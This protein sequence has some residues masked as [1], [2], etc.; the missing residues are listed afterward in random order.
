MKQLFLLCACLM[1]GWCFSQDCAPKDLEK[2]F[3]TYHTKFFLRSGID[4]SAY[5]WN[6]AEVNCHLN[7]AELNRRQQVGLRAGGFVTLGIGVGTL[8][9]GLSILDMKNIPRNTLG[10][11]LA[12]AGM[13]TACVSIPLIVLQGVRG[14]KARNHMNKAIAL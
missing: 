3:G 9:A 5:R 4:M 1:C 2:R 10:K 7:R 6:N 8:I 12:F 14:Q 13:G 11:T